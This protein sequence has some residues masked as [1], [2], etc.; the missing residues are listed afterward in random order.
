MKLAA[1]TVNAV[2][3][4]GFWSSS[5]GTLM[6]IAF[7]LSLIFD[8]LFVAYGAS[9]L[10]AP[11]FVTMMVSIHHLFA[12]CGRGGSAIHLHTWNAAL[13]TGYAGLCTF[14][15]GNSCSGTCFHRQQ[16]QSV[17]QMAV[18]SQWSSFYLPDP[19]SARVD[20]AD[21]CCRHRARNQIGVYA[22]LV[23]AFYV[24]VPTALV[25]VLFKRAK[26]G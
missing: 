9:F 16:T 21:K 20:H 5:A 13:R 3:Q 12:D 7:P 25:A 6:L 23:W 1:D 10:L 26:R 18:H 15:P 14:L 19:H 24:A 11:A 2:A 17:D 22:N 4:L 8:S